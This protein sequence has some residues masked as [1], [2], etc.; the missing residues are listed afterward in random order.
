MAKKVSTLY[1]MNVRSP[2]FV[3]ATDEGKPDSIASDFDQDTDVDSSD[4]ADDDGEYDN[5][6]L[7]DNP[8]DFVVPDFGIQE[9]RCGDVVNVSSDIGIRQYRLVD[10][11]GKSGDF[12][13]DY[14]INVPIR[15]SSDIPTEGTNQH[16][17][18][19]YGNDEYR[20]EL[21][22]T[23]KVS[24]SQLDQLTSGAVAVGSITRNKTSEDTQLTWQ[25]NSPIETDDYQL[26]FRCPGST[27]IPA[28]D[29]T[30]PAT[31]PA[32]NAIVMN[33]LAFWYSD[34]SN[35]DSGGGDT[36]PN[37]KVSL[38][39]NGTEVVQDMNFDEVYVVSDQSQ[40]G[41]LKWYEVRNRKGANVT[42]T[43]NYINRG[44]NMKKGANDVR[45]KGNSDA[46]G[47][48][49]MARLGIYHDGTSYKFTELNDESRYSFFAAPM[50]QNSFIHYGGLGFTRGVTS[51]YRID[52]FEPAD[53][54]H[55]YLQNQIAQ[56][57]YWL[58]S[59]IRTAYNSMT[60]TRYK[61]GSLQL[62]R[63]GYNYHF[64]DVITGSGTFSN[65]EYGIF[66]VNSN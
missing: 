21:I 57:P 40:L 11:V 43:T 17:E 36:K 54:T 58:G 39:I 6:N 22:Q 31:P 49:R 62:N 47:V 34:D 41:N 27:V 18:K 26:T 53:G 46:Y 13:L 44:T 64:L 24:T 63:G 12:V 65:G 33:V 52:W 3:I 1:K 30:L 7:P 37:S 25:V 59:S 51:E 45:L 66:N 38:E 61:N 50:G 23:G 32:D 16:F 4:Q 8:D 2:Y 60:V 42:K 28:D 20:D 55:A 35:I 9:V 19:F 48:V 5:D 15:F 14:T 29:R 56:Y 10:S